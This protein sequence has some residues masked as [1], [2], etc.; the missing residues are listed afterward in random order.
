[1]AR[2]AGHAVRCPAGPHLP[3]LLLCSRL[4][5]QRGVALF[6]RRG[7]VL[8]CLAAQL[9][10]LLQQGRRAGRQW[11][12][13][14]GHAGLC[15]AVT[16]LFSANQPSSPSWLCAACPGEH[17][18][19][20]WPARQARG[21][22]AHAAHAGS[23]LRRLVVAGHRAQGALG[24]QLGLRQL[25]GCSLLVPPAWYN[26]MRKPSG[27]SQASTQPLRQPAPPA[28]RTSGAPPTAD[29]STAG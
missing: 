17:R 22:A 27:Y 14:V 3:L 11:E 2:R 9:L 18:R 21:T 19:P 6:Q 28:V 25:L 26:P 1:M 15:R 5:G 20:L 29:C 7:A 16:P 4:G 23:R 8:L 13:L 24:I 12:V 10:L